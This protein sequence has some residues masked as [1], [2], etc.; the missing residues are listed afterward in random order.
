MEAYPIPEFMCDTHDG[1]EWALA[2]VLRERVVALRYISDIA[3]S[4]VDAQ[5]SEPSAELSIRQWLHKKPTELRDIQSLG[6][7]SAGVVSSDGF[8][9]RWAV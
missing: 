9:E 8:M 4:E 1:D 5:I 7:V 6:V 3:P 2:A